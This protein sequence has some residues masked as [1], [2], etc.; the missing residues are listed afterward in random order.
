MRFILFTAVKCN[1][2]DD[3]IFY[4]SCKNILHDKSIPLVFNYFL[5]MD[6]IDLNK[7]Q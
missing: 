6:K 7:Q 4:F 5:A 3:Y 2:L 1:A